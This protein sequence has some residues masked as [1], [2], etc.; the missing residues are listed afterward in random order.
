[1]AEEIPEKRGRGAPLGNKNGV[2]NRPWRA[3]ID[4]ALEKK[5]LVDKMEALDVIA[6][7][8][9]ETALAGPNYEKG[10]PWLAAVHELAD[11]LDGKAAQQ[12]QLSGDSDQPLIVEVVRFADK[13]T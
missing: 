6:E 2:K 3:A 9:V 10:D 11:R 7:K 1:M 4:R 13:A 5:S 8:V 12:L